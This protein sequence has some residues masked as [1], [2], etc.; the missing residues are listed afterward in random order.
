[1][2]R[3]L[4][5]DNYDSFTYNLVQYFMELGTEVEV[6]RNDAEPL[7][8]IVQ[9]SIEGVVVSPGP[10]RPEDSGVSLESVKDF[11]ERRIP[12]LGVCLCHQ[13]IGQA[14]GCEIT[15]A[16]RLMHGKVSE[17]TH[18]GNGLFV[19]LPNPFE[20]TRYH[21]LVVS[22][23]SVPQP[24][25]VCAHSEDG[26]IMGIKHRQLPIVGVQFHP[27]SVM[28]KM[29]KSIVRNFLDMCGEVS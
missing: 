1:M 22:G 13:C 14:F 24:L 25:E 5:I 23:K 10:G 12:L 21:S 15:G 6:V 18:N 3:I 2:I 28:T 8:R 19:G 29:G 7:D 27:E 26:E 4:V 9:R 16:K 20:A 11:G 17:I